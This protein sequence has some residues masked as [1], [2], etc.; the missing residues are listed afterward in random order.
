MGDMEECVDMQIEVPEHGMAVHQALR[1]AGFDAWFV[2]G[3]VRDAVLGRQAHDVDIATD[4]RWPQVQAAC[5][6]AG[7]RTHETG[8]KHGTLTVVPDGEHAV[9]VTTFRTDGAYLDGRH[10]ENVAFVESIEEDL[11]RRDFTMNALAYQPECGLFDPLGGLED[12]RRGLIRVVGTPDER[13]KEDALRILRACRFASQL[14]FAIE[15]ETASAL[16]THKHLIQ[17]VS[18][19]RVTHELDEL[20]MGEFP[21]DALMA[22][23]DVLAFAI[24]ELAAMNGCEQRTK[25]HCF[26]VLEHTA[27]AVQFAER[28]R[29]VRWAALCH[30]MGKPASAFF[31]TDGVEHFY[32]HAHVSAELARGVARRMLMSSAFAADLALLVQLHSEKI[33]PTRRSVR[34]FLAKLGGRPE[35]MRALLQLKRADMAAH[36][37]EY[38]ADA[39]LMDEVQQVLDAVLSEKD[40]FSVEMLAVNGHDVMSWGVPEGRCVGNMLAWLLEEVIEERVPNERAA[41]RAAAEAR[42]QRGSGC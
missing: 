36:A 33:A 16:R 9:E 18:Q 19:E 42:T 26:D 10:P 21:H 17:N 1:A 27:W 12:I 3:Y 35:L 11:K 32:G 14:G 8:T 34:R 28:S 15:P 20:L 38:A 13:F 22:T 30:D 39:A 31:A 4:A 23:A 37:P 7:F 41:L 40:A 6:A 2:G 24:P 29:L 5:A 25:Y